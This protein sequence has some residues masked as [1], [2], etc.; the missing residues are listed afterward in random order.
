M[1]KKNNGIGLITILLLALSKGQGGKDRS[2][3]GKKKIK[4]LIV[5]Y[6]KTTLPSVPGQQLKEGFLP[7][8]LF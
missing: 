4:N 1:K 6:S 7:L 3:P 2:I 5:T 8:H